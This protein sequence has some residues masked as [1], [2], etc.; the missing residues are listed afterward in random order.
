[1]ACFKSAGLQGT[2]VGIHKLPN[3]AHAL[4]RGLKSVFTSMDE[5][6]CKDLFRFAQQLDNT[7]ELKRAACVI[8]FARTCMT[9]VSTQLKSLLG[10]CTTGE[11][12]PEKVKHKEIAFALVQVATSQSVAPIRAA[13][14]KISEINGRVLYRVELWREMHKAMDEY[15]SGRHPSLLQAA[16]QIRR[17]T[18]MV[19][20]RLP[21]RTI[22]RTLLIKGLEFDHAV[23]F[24]VKETVSMESFWLQG[25]PDMW[26]AAGPPTTH[27][28]AL[29]Y[30]SAT[31]LR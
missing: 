4:A 15:E 21:R 22:S 26:R 31:I 19:G 24:P 29:R 11:I 5:V 28:A 1:M 7:S 6:Y 20:R 23:S 16:W 9:E 2:V 17:R 8:E 18:S 12:R 3:Q 14:D 30:N 27:G 10:M 25:W 13:L